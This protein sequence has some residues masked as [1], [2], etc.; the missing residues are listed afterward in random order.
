MVCKWEAVRISK[1]SITDRERGKKANE[2]E[3]GARVTEKPKA[4]TPPFTAAP[5]K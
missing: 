5:P 1:C 2:L 4:L 3:K